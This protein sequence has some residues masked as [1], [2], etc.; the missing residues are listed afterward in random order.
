[1]ASAVW[2]ALEP[3]AAVFTRVVREHEVLR[4]SARIGRGGA[5]AQAA[6]EQARKEILVWAENRI[7]SKLSASAW[8]LEQFEHLSG[9]RNCSAVRIR[10]NG[11]DVWALRAEDPDKEVAG[12]V[13]TTE[14][15]TALGADASPRFSL[16]LIASSREA[17]LAVEP[18]TPGLVQQL[19]ETCGLWHGAY[20]LTCE[21]RVISDADDAGHLG[22]MLIDSQRTLPVIAMSVPGNSFGSYD[23]L[24]N[25]GALARATLGLAHV[26]I[27]PAEHTWHLT[28]R[29]GKRLATYGGAIRTYMSGFTEEADPYAHRLFLPG[30]LQSWDGAAHAVRI[31]RSAAAHESI[32]R[33]KLGSDV[34]AFSEIKSAALKLSLQDLERKGAP[35]HAQLDAARIQIAALEKYKE[36]AKAWEEAILAEQ[37]AAEER[38]ELAESQ[39]NKATFRNQQL[40]AQIKAQGET[41][42]SNIEPP[43]RWEELEDWCDTHLSGRLV[44]SPL[45]RRGLRS[46][47][48]ESPDIA[49]RCLLWLANDCREALMGDGTGTIREQSVLDGVKNAH[50]GSDQF[51]FNWQGRKLS[52]VWHIKNGGNT[53]DPK[54]CLR[55]YF[56]WDET[57]QQIVVADMPAH[58]D[59]A[60]T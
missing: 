10:S 37:A 2:A 15:I 45:A 35:E 23:T 9:G 16:R 29:F 40:L 33:T 51:D 8:N 26:V 31:L 21:P 50:C 38:A 17:S 12:R 42:D 11:S 48:F 1:M 52:A 43:A 56:A 24:I 28:E 54:R 20:Q 13:W 18:H 32:R 27:V 46:P 44:L 5:T 25:P 59:S 60:A 19:A 4:V 55:I 6:L 34:L 49:A 53:R 41:P 30:T 7:G 22:E 14:V 3:I 39:Y 36:E 58:R 57:T 47:E